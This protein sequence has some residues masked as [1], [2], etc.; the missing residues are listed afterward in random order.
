MYNPYNN[1]ERG[2]IMILNLKCDTCAFQNKCIAKLKLKP[3]SNEARVD[4]GV[5]LNFNKCNNYVELPEEEDE[6]AKEEA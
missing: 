3:F 4:F 2:K 1:L 6:E 5:E